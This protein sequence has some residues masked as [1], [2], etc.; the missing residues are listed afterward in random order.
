MALPIIEPLRKYAIFSGRARRNEYWPFIGLAILL[1]IAGRIS[2]GS[3]G[4][5]SPL[6]GLIQ[7][8][9]LIPTIAA[10]WR[11]A[12]DSGH[13]GWGILIPVYN[14]YV[15]LQPTQDGPNEYGPDPRFSYEELEQTFS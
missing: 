12:H 15:A 1:N 2:A 6:I 4:T 8:A 14:L 3:T 5:G 10:G 9:I 7:L 11:R 13:A